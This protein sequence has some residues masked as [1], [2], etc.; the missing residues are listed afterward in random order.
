[1]KHVVVSSGLHEADIRPPSLM[2]EFRRLSIEEA[3]SFFG[4][5]TNLVDIDCPACGNAGREAVFD[6]EGFTYNRCDRC[7][8]V[9]VSPR[10]THDMLAE[11]YRTSKASHFRVEQLARDTANARRAHLLHSHANWLGRLVDERGNLEARR[12]VDIGTNLT[13]VFDEFRRLGLFDDLYC[14]NPLPSLEPELEALSV[15]IRHD[16]PENQ[17]AV[18][19]F[20]QLEHQFS[21]LD[22]IT[23]A[24]DML[25]DRGLFFF[26]TRTI[27][28]F[29]LQMLWD[30]APY[31]FVPEHLNLMSVEGIQ[32][33][34]AR[35]GMDVVELSTP[36]QLD[37]EL[38]LHAVQQ[39][40]TIELP[41]FV[42]YLLRQRGREVH[43]D[44][45]AF[46]QRARLSSHVRVAAT[47]TMKDTA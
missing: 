29:D 10:P 14:L 25:V 36:G 20:E 17:G 24:R 5:A 42:S 6:K 32:E 27:S 9:F 19:A 8:S 11:Y 12:C 43:E 41:P 3:R 28:G 21:P 18:T 30:K 35:A 4:D 38:T 1:M 47:P 16:P 13:L 33:L 26:T 7:A 45:Q 15:Q 39:D 37:L 44:F 46:L 40:D 23:A 31:I 34:I 22:F 2:S